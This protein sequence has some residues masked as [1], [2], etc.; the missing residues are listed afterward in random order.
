MQSKSKLFREKQ[1][2]S[3][4][5]VFR[6]RSSGDVSS[7]MERRPRKRKGRGPDPRKAR[8]RMVVY[9]PNLHEHVL[10][11]VNHI[12]QSENMLPLYTLVVGLAK[13]GTMP[14]ADIVNALYRA[15]LESVAAGK[16]GTLRTAKFVSMTGVLLRRVVL[17]FYPIQVAATLCFVTDWEVF[18]DIV[19]AAIECPAAYAT[20]P[21]DVA[22]AVFWQ[23]SLLQA[24]ADGS[25]SGK[26]TCLG[27]LIAAAG[28]PS[29]IGKFMCASA[30]RLS[31]K[32]RGAP[33][34]LSFFGVLALL[35]LCNAKI[36]SCLFS[37]RHPSPKPLS[38]AA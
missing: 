6:D 5:R 32:E 9:G 21:L 23:D 25:V 37:R 34:T 29:A 31:E 38:L 12:A 17:F 36:A 15:M 13:S 22:C 28:R 8:D 3:R 4:K 14:Q 7:S 18:Q 16:E 27:R 24:R 33:S 30:K 11:E 10:I 20:I 19:S 35:L 1:S 26:S 2:P